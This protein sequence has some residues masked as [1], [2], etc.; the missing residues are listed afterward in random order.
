TCEDGKLTALVGDSGC[1]KS[2]ALN[3][4]AQYYRPARGTV[5]IGGADTAAYAPESVLA[6]VS[7]VDQNVFLFDDS[8]MDNIR[9]A[10]PGATDDEVRE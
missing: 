3:L 7:V 10:R 8:V 6:G 5:R 1:G 9:Y 2:T 4:I